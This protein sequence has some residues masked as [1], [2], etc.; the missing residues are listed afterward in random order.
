MVY[1][2]KRDIKVYSVY[3]INKENVWLFALFVFHAKNVKEPWERI[4]V[5]D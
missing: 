3:C 5:S 4:Y 1:V 2:S